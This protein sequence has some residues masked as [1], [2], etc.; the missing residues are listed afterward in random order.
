MK[1]CGALLAVWASVAIG[2]GGA[3]SRPGVDAPQ[4][5]ALGPHA[6]GWRTVRLAQHDPLDMPTVDADSGTAGRQHRTL[7]VDLWYPALP[8]AP[9]KVVTY[10]GEMSGE[11]PR[12]PVRFSIAGLAVHDARPEPGRYPLVVVS[13][14][15]ANASVAMSWLTENLASKGYVVAAIRHADPDYSDQPG[16]A[17]ALYRRPLDIGFV[18]R[19]LQ[20]LLAH[21]GLI[22]PQ[23]TALI[24]YSI[25]G[26]GVLT[27]AGA[28]IDPDTA[29]VVQSPGGQMRRYARGGAEQSAVQV[30]GL[31]ALVAIAPWGGQLQPWGAS[32]VGQIHVPLLIIGGDQ[33]HTADYANG[34]RAIFEQATGAQRYLLTYRNAGHNIGLA[35]IPE[36]MRGR[37]WDL[38]WFADPV[39]RNERIV[40]INLHMITAFLDRYVKNDVSR[41]AYLDVPVPE[42][43]DAQWPADSKAPWDAYSP[44]DEGITVWKGF[45]RRELTGLELRAL[46]PQTPAN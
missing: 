9:A 15:L 28:Q 27:S 42:G 14:G 6:V 12:P 3:P 19:S 8:A 4:L 40:A 41:A 35:P 2:A 25:G 29:L 1:R 33:D 16:A 45:Q 34:I 37:L 38:D 36:T 26:F 31:R 43:N 44:G 13:H 32:G 10:Q 46:A 7:L 18:T 39:W 24:G 17:L 21:D 20:Q 22:D 30:Q 23:L 5:A 11:P